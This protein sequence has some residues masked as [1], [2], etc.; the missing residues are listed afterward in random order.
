M[1]RRVLV[2]DD[3]QFVR[4]ALCE[5]FIREGD[6]DVCGQATDGQ[7]AIEKV[8][9]SNTDLFVTDLSMAV[10]SGLDETRFSK[11]GSA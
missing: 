10:M 1:I 9:E 3:N 8:L 11:T 5:L 4:R 2:V 7:D 6:F